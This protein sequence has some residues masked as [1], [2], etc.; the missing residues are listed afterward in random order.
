MFNSTG[1]RELR[2]GKRYQTSTERTMSNH[3]R[4]EELANRSSSE[5]VE[6]EISE[7]QTLTQQ[8][9]NEQIRGVIAPLTRQ[10]GVD[11]A[12]TKNDHFTASEFL[13]QD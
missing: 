11:L 13:P 10:R 9:A 6:G 5:K 8:A 3:G 1:Y 12:G 7:F 2:N 4:T